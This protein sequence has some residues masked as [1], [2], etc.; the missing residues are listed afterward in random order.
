MP[1]Y[2]PICLSLERKPC[3]VVGGGEVALRKALSLLAAGADVTVVSPRFCEELRNLSGIRRIERPFRESDAAGA[4][5][6][7][8]ATDDP[9]VNTAVAAAAREHGALVNVVD[10]PAEC[11]FIVPSSLT[12]GRLTISVA[13]A[14]AAP[15]LAQRLRR[16][17]E[18]LFPQDYAAFVEVLGDLRARVSREVPDPKRRKAILHRLASREAW[19]LFARDG[20]D[21]I[22]QLAARL[23]E[24]DA[25]PNGG[26]A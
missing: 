1:Q 4:L 16:E 13:T 25:P 14:G 24:P 11:D 15:A 17:L 21:A 3:L 6:V 9:A 7:Y 22:R 12:R 19:E 5:L 10:T 18:E 20:P 2:Y 23:I 8:A 26:S